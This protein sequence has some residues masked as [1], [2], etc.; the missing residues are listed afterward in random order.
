MELGD[1]VVLEGHGL[2]FRSGV[3]FEKELRNGSHNE[4]GGWL[5]EERPRHPRLLSV[6]YASVHHALVVPIACYLP[7]LTPIII[8]NIIQNY[9]GPLNYNRW[10]KIRYLHITIYNK[11]NSKI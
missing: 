5:Q 1:G 11:K 7:P 9:V 6:H 10:F 8:L 3:V 2:V 4:V